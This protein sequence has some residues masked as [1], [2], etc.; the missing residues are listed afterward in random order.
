MRIA[1]RTVNGFVIYEGKQFG[2]E[3]NEEFD[4][5]M[6]APGFETASVIIPHNMIVNGCIELE[7]SEPTMGVMFSEFRITK[8]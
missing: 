4:R 3:T 5:E 1:K 8:A 6:L 2:S 7:L